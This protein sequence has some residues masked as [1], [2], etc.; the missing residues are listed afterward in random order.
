MLFRS[1]KLGIVAA[2]AFLLLLLAICFVFRKRLNDRLIVITALLMAVGIPFFLPHM[3][4]RYF[5]G[6][7]MMTLA[8]GCVAL[9]L[10]RMPCR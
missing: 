9:P 10:V 7:D 5:Y 2:F 4:D 8:L 1:A 6:A 3:H